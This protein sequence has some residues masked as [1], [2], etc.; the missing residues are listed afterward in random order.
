MLLFSSCCPCRQ[1]RGWPWLLSF[2]LRF[3]S[4]LSLTTSSITS[5]QLRLSFAVVLYS[6]PTLS[7]SLL[8]QSSHRMLGLPRLPFPSLHFL[9]ICSFNNCS[10]SH[11]FHMSGPFQP[12]PPQFLLK[13]FFHTNLHSQF[14]HSGLIRSLHS[15]DSSYPVVFANLH[16][17]LL[18]PC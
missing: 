12:T 8:T 2:F 4:S 10:I 7:R 5:L 11:S 9:G 18:F 6:P 3:L 15:H 17:L 1:G 14:G 13:T 16:L